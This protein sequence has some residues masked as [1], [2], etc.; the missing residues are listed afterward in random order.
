[1]QL[2]LYRRTIKEIPYA[3]ASSFPQTLPHDLLVQK[4]A[5]MA[6]TC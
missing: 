1:M 4:C 6:H 5:H 2:V 3:H